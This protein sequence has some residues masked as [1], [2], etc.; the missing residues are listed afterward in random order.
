MV[1]SLAI[2]KQ[3]LT[4]GLDFVR[5][6]AASPRW[7]SFVLAPSG[8]LCVDVQTTRPIY[9]HQQNSHL[10][11]SLITEFVSVIMWTFKRNY[12]HSTEAVAAETVCCWGCY[13]LL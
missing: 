9:D 4:Q 10:K 7:V 8:H 13:W 5:K 11:P 12:W 6:F 3:L 2:L 1:L